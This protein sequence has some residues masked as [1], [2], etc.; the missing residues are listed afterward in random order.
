MAVPD[1]APG[2]VRAAAAAR[3]RFDRRKGLCR[4]A[5]FGR[6]RRDHRLG[7]PYRCGRQ[8]DRRRQSECHDL[9]AHCRRLRLETSPLSRF[10][11]RIGH[12]KVTSAVNRTQEVGP[13][14][15]VRPPV[16][17]PERLF[18]GIA[19]YFPGFGIDQMNAAARR[20]GHGFKSVPVPAPARL[21][22]REQPLDVVP[23]R[24][25]TIDERCH[26]ERISDA[27]DA[28]NYV[29]IPRI[30]DYRRKFTL[31]LKS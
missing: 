1:K 6:S 14:R 11:Q 10:D 18:P 3:G 28:I 22:I 20:T 30:S 4:S 17:S 19:E 5:D 21:V 15:E 2:A 29:N 27:F 24:R 26:K 7:P 25:A 31:E 8:Q 9:R 23:G 13:A 16:F 12:A